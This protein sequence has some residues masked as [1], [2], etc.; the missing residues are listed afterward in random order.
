[1]FDFVFTHFTALLALFMTVVSVISGLR[2]LGAGYIWHFKDGI[3]S[4]IEGDA[5]AW[6]YLL[7]LLSTVL[8]VWHAGLL[9]D[10]IIRDGRFMIGESITDNWNLW[11]TLTSAYF[12]FVH[13]MVYKFMKKRNARGEYHK[14]NRLWGK[15]DKPD[16]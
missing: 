9:T 5:N 2:V 13:F 6:L 8:S 14:V 12:S 15:D 16:Y 10:W 7:V 1:M 3:K 4:Y 11:H